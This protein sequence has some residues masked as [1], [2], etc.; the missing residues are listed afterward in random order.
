MCFRWI[1]KHIFI[2]SI[3]SIVSFSMIFGNDIP[4]FWK[5]VAFTV[6]CVS[7]Q[8]LMLVI[9]I[10]IVP[11]IARTFIK[12]PSNKIKLILSLICLVAIS[13]F[14]SVMISYISA[15]HF[16]PDINFIG[17]IQYYQVTEPVESF[18]TINVFSIDFAFVSIFAITLGIILHYKSNAYLLNLLENYYEF[19]KKII[20]KIFLIFL[21]VY[22]TGSML[23]ITH[24]IDFMSMIPIFVTLYIFI[25]LIQTMYVTLLFFIASG[26]R[27]SSC[28]LAIKNTIPALLVGFSTMSSIVTLP[29]TLKSV[30]KNTNNCNIAKL[31]VSTTVNCHVVGDC[32]SLPLVALVILYTTHGVIPELNLYLLFAGF[33]ALIQFSAISVPGGSSVVILPILAKYLGFTDE[34]SSI[35]IAISICIEPFGTAMN[36]AGNSAFAIIVSRLFRKT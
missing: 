2:I 35:I 11:L 6:S 32:I 29:T 19:S 31:T 22:V 16:I 1:I 24:E 13:N 30:A 26:F 8:V 18:I 23:K 21:P 10:F 15:I 17:H 14:F 9:P 28:I 3:L 5:R 36:I 33:V 12:I 25:L 20:E 27:T 4:I 7:K 34:M